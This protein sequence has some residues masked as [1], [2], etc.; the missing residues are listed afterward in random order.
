MTDFASAL[1][2]HHKGDFTHAEAAYRQMLAQ[3]PDH[4]EALH[5]LAALLHQTGRFEEALTWFSQA[6]VANP[7]NPRLYH[8]MGETLRILGRHPDAEACFRVAMALEPGFAEAIASR[9]AALA[10]MGLL[11]EAISCLR[12]GLDLAQDHGRILGN[13]A[14]ALHQKG[15]VA[16]SLPLFDRA[17]AALP[18]DA[19]LH[20]NRA[21]A[22]LLVGAY[23]T[24]LPALEWRWRV[25]RFPSPPRDFLQP[26]WMGEDFSGRRLLLHAEQGI[27]DS[28]QLIRFIPMVAARGGSV[29]LEVQKPLVTLI[30]SVPGL[31]HAITQI[32][33]QGEPLPDFDL[34]CPLMSLPEI[35]EIRLSSIPIDRYLTADPLRV[36]RWRARL[37]GTGR[38]RV[39]LV[40]AGNAAYS[41]DTKR[42]LPP[43]LL[44]PL[45]RV[46]AIDWFSLQVGRSGPLPFQMTDLASDLTD[47]AET[48]AV[49]DTLDL[50]ITVDTAIAHLAGGLGHLAWV[51]LPQ[52]PDW[53]WLLDRTDSV[54]YP[55]LRLFRQ[56]SPGDWRGLIARIAAELVSFQSSRP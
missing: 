46:D 36:T 8:N 31:S 16:K 56:P 4:G 43:H 38:P 10:E 19:L 7:G 49:L 9:G 52:P 12:A 27:G 33:A 41:V 22:H 25:P 42:S 1:A 54:C 6:F 18:Q 39:A 24:G 48:A 3:Q 30:T 15:E 26:R 44:A 40:W 37:P 17:V 21:L 23:E 13:L 2:A 51:M 45:A 32:V 5:M 20:W 14:L 53:R 28:L 34:Q 55:S 50:L 35:F 47:F 29:I 11:E